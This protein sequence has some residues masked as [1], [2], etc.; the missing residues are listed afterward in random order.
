MLR[1]VVKAWVKKDQ[2][3]VLERLLSEDIPT[4]KRGEIEEALVEGLVES[5]LEA[6]ADFVVGL[7][8][9]K[10]ATRD[11]ARGVVDKM[12]D[13]DPEAA[14]LWITEH[15]RAE[16]AQNLA[17]IVVNK[18]SKTDPRVAV[19]MA[20]DLPSNN[21][22]HSLRGECAPSLGVSGRKC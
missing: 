10:N 14:L 9:G 5:D 18:I 8:R 3:A 22:T 13:S 12:A 20:Y 2:P 1:A 19:E 17:S 21:G 7:K 6:A 4:N 15:F 11:L 16:A